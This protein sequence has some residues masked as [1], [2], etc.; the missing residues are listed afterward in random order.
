MS[1]H[2]ICFRGEIWKIFTRYPTLSRPML[3]GLEYVLSVAMAVVVV[4]LLGSA[5]EKSAFEHMLIFRSHI[6]CM[7]EVSLEPLLSVDT[8]CRIQWYWERL[9]NPWSACAAAQSDLDLQCPRM[10]RRHIFSWRGSVDL[11]SCVCIKIFSKE[12]PIWLGRLFK[13]KRCCYP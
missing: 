2:N 7:C 8:F 6:L 3:F 12:D 1:T 9:V 10:P 13:K 11:S 5:V 4:R